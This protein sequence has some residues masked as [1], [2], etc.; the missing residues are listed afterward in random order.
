MDY[1]LLMT[2]QPI[3]YEHIESLSHHRIITPFD[4][5]QKSVNIYAYYPQDLTKEAKIQV[6]RLLGEVYF[7]KSPVPQDQIER[8]ANKLRQQNSIKV[9]DIVFHQDYKKLP[10]KVTKLDTTATIVHNLRMRPLEIECDPT[11]LHLAEQQELPIY[12]TDKPN[13]DYPNKVYL[14]CDIFTSQN[15]DDYFRSIFIALMRLRLTYISHEIVLVNPITDL[16]FVSNLGFR[17]V[18]GNIL[19][20]TDQ[21]DP[22]PLIT[23][24]K[25]TAYANIRAYNGIRFTRPSFI[26]SQEIDTQVHIHALVTKSKHTRELL[27]RI[28]NNQAQLPQPQHPSYRPTITQLPPKPTINYQALKTKLRQ[29]ELE[30][31]ITRIDEIIYTLRGSQCRTTRI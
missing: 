9:G 3:K 26:V 13:I 20:L 15:I 18:Y 27:L 16:S 1:F 30:G 14:D 8:Q 6:Q 2:T 24:S 12:N 4:S 5:K 22:S 17:S 29:V 31:Y 7:T 19:A 10:F 11:L 21:I 23:N 28:K 25:L